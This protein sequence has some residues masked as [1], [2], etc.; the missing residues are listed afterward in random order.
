MWFLKEK[1][2]SVC[3]TVIWG[4]CVNRFIEKNGKNVLFYAANGLGQNGFTGS[5]LLGACG[6]TQTRYKNYA[7]L[8]ESSFLWWI[9]TMKHRGG[10]WSGKPVNFTREIPGS[11][12]VQSASILNPLWC[13]FLSIT[14]NW[15]RGKWSITSMKDQGGKDHRTYIKTM[16]G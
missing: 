12:L 1:G 15:S 14:V 10:R 7:L 4:E 6:N 5:L 2:I 8:N 11:K 9:C 13:F 3:G 16:E